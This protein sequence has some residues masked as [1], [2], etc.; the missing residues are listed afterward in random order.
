MFRNFENIIEDN[1]AIMISHRI[2]NAVSADKI[3]VIDNGVI[4]ES[5]SHKELIEKRGM[6][7]KMYELQRSKYTAAEE[8]RDE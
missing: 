6:Y 1:T 7:A 8:N 3:L 5:G 4:A 2:S